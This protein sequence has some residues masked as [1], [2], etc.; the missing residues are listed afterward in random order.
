M[1]PTQP[2]EPGGERRL[3]PLHPGHEVRLRGF[4]REMVVKPEFGR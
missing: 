3:Q 2:V 1:F 4:Q